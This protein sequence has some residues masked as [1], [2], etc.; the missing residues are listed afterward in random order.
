M[1]DWLCCRIPARLKS[2]SKSRKCS[3]AKSRLCKTIWQPYLMEES[4]LSSKCKSKG[5]KATSFY[6]RDT[7][8]LLGKTRD[9]LKLKCMTMSID[10]PSIPCKKRRDWF[11]SSLALSGGTLRAWLSNLGIISRALWPKYRNR[12][13]LI[14]SFGR[15]TSR[16]RI[17]SS[18]T[19][20]F[21]RTTSCCRIRRERFRKWK[22][23]FRGRRNWRPIRSKWP[24]SRK[25]GARI[26]QWLRPWTMSCLCS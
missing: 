19:R 25:S 21:R 17:L 6:L 3:G 5:R 8:Q 1:R 20:S 18:E 10:R 22:T 13:M 26:V 15:M 14:W 2:S 4:Q 11:M 12:I 7:R 16:R 9:C 24:L 23:I